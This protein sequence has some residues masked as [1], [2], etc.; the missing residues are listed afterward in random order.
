[1]S[2][3]HPILKAI[4]DSC[5]NRHRSREIIRENLGIG[6]RPS[7][8]KSDTI[9]CAIEDRINKGDWV[10][11]LQ[12]NA[13]GEEQMK[14]ISTQI[15]L[16]LRD[17]DVVGLCEYRSINNVQE[18]VIPLSAWSP[19]TDGRAASDLLATNVEIDLIVI[20]NPEG[21]LVLDRFDLDIRP[22]VKQA[23]TAD[24]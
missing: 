7:P 20:R 5:G 6:R 10:F 2:V 19:S 21:Q 18:I 13:F 4:Y 12:A 3:L 8:G 22:A 24:F 11:S 17:L 15:P 1:M 9:F 14:E 23:R 16:L